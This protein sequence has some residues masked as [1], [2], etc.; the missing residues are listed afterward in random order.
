M[1]KRCFYVSPF[2]ETHSMKE[3]PTIL[4]GTRIDGGAGDSEEGGGWEEAKGMD[5]EEEDNHDP[6]NF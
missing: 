6:F 4:A 5:F 2:I 1:R 3:M